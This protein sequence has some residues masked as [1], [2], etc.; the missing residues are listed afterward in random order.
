MNARTNK[1]T[2]PDDSPHGGENERPQGDERPQPN[3]E[4]KEPP[5]AGQ[6]GFKDKFPRKGDI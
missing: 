5:K 6:R 4:V 1:P 3:T 2:K